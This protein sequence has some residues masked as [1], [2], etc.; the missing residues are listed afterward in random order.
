MK[1]VFLDVEGTWDPIWAALWGIDVSRVF[2]IRP[3][4]AE[5]TSDAMQ[6]FITADDVNFIAVDSLGA[7][8]PKGEV[9]D[10]STK[11]HYGGA[12]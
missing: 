11:Q 7:M 2:V 12:A 6:L 4:F 3:D 9:E 8:S 5:Q 1:Q 10:N